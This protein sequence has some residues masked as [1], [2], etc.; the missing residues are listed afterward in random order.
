MSKYST[1]TDDVEAQSPVPVPLPAAS[2]YDDEAG[3]GIGMA[4]FFCIVLGSALAWIPLLGAVIGASIFLIAA[5]VLA[6]TIT[7][8]CCGGSNLNLNPKVKRWSTAALIC[9][10]I[11]WILILIASFIV[12]GAIN[13]GENDVYVGETGVIMAL[14]VVSG[15][16]FFLAAVFA[17]I[18]TWGRKSCGNA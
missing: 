4:M 1:S 6:S 9:L 12:A 13:E 5:I 18:F 11:H 15:I 14:N 2:G 17:G 3:K 8:G 10:V 7:C 16:L